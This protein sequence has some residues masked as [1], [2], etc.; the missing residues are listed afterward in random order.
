MKKFIYFLFGKPYTESKF[1]T[2]GYWFAVGFYFLVITT[3]I[4]QTIILGGWITLLLGAIL[5]PITFRI[6]YII[7]I[8]IIKAFKG[9]S[10][11]VL[12]ILGLIFR[13]FTVGIFTVSLLF[14][15]NVSIGTSKSVINGEVKLSISSL[16]GYYDVESFDV[17][18]NR[19][20]SIPYIAS[21]GEGKFYMYVED[22]EDTVWEEQITDA[23]NG[24]IEFQGETGT[25]NISIYTEEA[26]KIKLNLSLD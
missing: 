12:L 18:E 7:D 4:I 21:V 11:R 26:K 6:V 15:D 3:S 9:R 24:V 14:G 19:I 13:L 25:Y 16:K 8:S 20:V 10:K 17:T 5:F 22:S 23:K 2:I 1:L